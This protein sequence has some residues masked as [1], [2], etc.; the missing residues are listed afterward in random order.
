MYK[1]HKVYTVFLTLLTLFLCYGLNVDYSRIAENAV[2]VVSISF[3]LHITVASSLL[4]S[5]YSRYLKKHTDPYNPTKSR[6][7]VIVA[8]LQNAG[9]ISV[10]TITISTL[11]MLMPD[12]F[13]MLSQSEFLNRHLDFLRRI[14]S[15]ASCALFA[16][17]FLFL[18]LIFI[19]LINSL[20]RPLEEE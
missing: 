15:S 4:G 9:I 8:Y 7:G 2:T 20:T 10:L 13:Q 14:I 16:I 3:A 6:L 18:W 5:D 11:Y 1:R 17:N 19:F 12:D